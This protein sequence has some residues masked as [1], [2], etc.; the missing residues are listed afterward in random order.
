MPNSIS[1]LEK[2]RVD[3]S[4]WKG[5]QLD[6]LLGLYYIRKNRGGKERFVMF[7]DPMI[8]PNYEFDQVVQNTHIYF[9]FKNDLLTSPINFTQKMRKN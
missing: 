7:G 3:K 6:I 2:K 1:L 5:S 9:N 4:Y 8:N